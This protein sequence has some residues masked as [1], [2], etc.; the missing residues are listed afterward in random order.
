M[1]PA[2]DEIPRRYWRPYL[3]RVGDLYQGWRVSI[4]VLSD[5]LGDQ[6]IVEGLP[7][8]GLSFETAG[9]EQGAILIEAGDGER[10]TI[11]RVARPSK[12]H[13]R[14]VGPGQEPDLLIESANGTSTLVMLRYV[15][16]LPRDTDDGT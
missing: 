12:V 2:L 1:F 16:A 10:F 6:P 5:E 14:H 9:S 4:E 8:R 11:H 7:L 15:I 13:G 3:G